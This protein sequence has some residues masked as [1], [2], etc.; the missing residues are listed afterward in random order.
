MNV[1]DSKSE[2]NSEPIQVFTKYKLNF[3]NFTTSTQQ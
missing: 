2:K 3:Y 1:H